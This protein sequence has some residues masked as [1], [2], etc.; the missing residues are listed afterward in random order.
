MIWLLLPLL[1]AFY[2]AKVEDPDRVEYVR[3][4]LLPPLLI[5]FYQ[6]KAEE[7]YLLSVNWLVEAYP[8]GIRGL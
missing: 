5:T 4:W 6:A 3:L 7:G 1:M 8:Y 2:Q